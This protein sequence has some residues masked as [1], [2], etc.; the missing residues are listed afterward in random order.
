MKKSV[1][2]ILIIASILIV[3][4]GVLGYMVYNHTMGSEEIVGK[5]DQIPSASKNIPPVTTG[6][7][8][9]TNWRGA[10]F[11]G[12]SNSTGIKTDWSNG[13]TKLWQV[14][15]LC[16]GSSAA[17]WSSPVV[18]GNR[19]VIMGRD[20]AN[21][22]VFCIN[23]ENGELIW[24]GS[25]AATATSSHGEGPRATPF[26]D[27][28]M[29]YTFGRSGDLTCWNL[30]DGKQV[31]KQNVK[32]NGGQEPEWGY[33][34]TPL[35]IDN[36]VIVQGGGN[37]LAIA[38]DKLTGNIIWKS[39]QGEAG[40]AAT[41]PVKIGEETELF[42]YHGK[43]LALVD[44]NDGKQYWNAPWETSY[45]VNASTPIVNNDIVFHT[46]AYG[47]GAEALK[48][49]KD[50]YKVAWKSGVIEGQHTD[51]ILIDGYLYSYSGESSRKKGMFKCV[52]LATGKEMWSTDEIGQGTA[53]FAD[54]H[55]ICFDITGNLYLAK[56]NPKSFELVGTIK[57]AMEDVKNPSWTVPVVANG[58]LYL[59]HLQHL[60][61]YN[62]M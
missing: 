60:I 27:N 33:S 15:Y 62:L 30:L 32:D 47:M 5:K 7:A 37:A 56:P 10:K 19:L 2:I 45:L 39:S 48:F 3:V 21:D 26:I 1:K 9:W 51:A 17:T 4:V 49:N 35:V 52:E 50:G 28:G 40:Y 57:K 43:G 46:S 6:T 44:L 31:W 34:T 13:L 59:R 38:Y 23:T 58:K 16:Q 11:D 25:Y 53:T 20:E 41:I 55:L 22:Y 36:K 18:Q 54:G 42:I 24:K 61:C 12:K 29:V 14:D 8:D